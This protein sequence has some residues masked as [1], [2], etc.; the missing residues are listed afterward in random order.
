LKNLAATLW[1]RFEK[2]SLQEDIDDSISLHRDALQ[3]LPTPHPSRSSSLNNLAAALGSRF[4]LTGQRNDLDATINT[5][6]ECLNTFGS[7][8]PLTCGISSNLGVTLA[9]AYSHTHEAEYL[10][11]AIAAFQ[12]SVAC[13]SAPISQRFSAARMWATHADNSSHESALDAYHIAIEFLPRLAMLGLDL[14][15]RQRVL[16]SCC[17]DGLAR[18]AAACALR[19]GRPDKAVELLE[20]GRAVFWAQALQLH[21][22]TTDLRDAAPELEEQL[23]RISIALEQGS[24]RD[25]SSSP[26]HT[27]QKVMSMEQEASHFRRLNDEW[28]AT[29][30]Q[31]RRLSGLQDFLRPSRLSTLQC[32]ATNGPIVVLNA[33]QTGCNAL[34]LTSTGVQTIPFPDLNFTLVTKL[35]KLLRYA[36]GH[37][38]R[39]APSPLLESNRALVEDILQQIPFISDILQLR[40]LSDRHLERVSTTSL[41]P[42][43]VF[44][45]VLGL[46][47]VSVA[48][49][50]IGMLELEVNPNL[51]KMGLSC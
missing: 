36:I 50:I 22:P 33:A 35:V 51:S 40:L 14:Q 7:G 13:E 32:A 38:G 24:F 3:L 44:R 25:E 31:V 16:A 4:N 18:E 43:E 12:V 45:F 11:K 15:S 29:L 34:I 1:A 17:D 30:E 46:L 2:F 41:Q 28:L 19:F 23:R 6:N 39:D 9:N 10:D 27:M 26:S 47:W 5:Y 21:K 20:E 42:D 37:D 49:P 48:K 8:H